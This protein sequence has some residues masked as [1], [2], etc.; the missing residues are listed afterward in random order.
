MGDLLRIQNLEKHYEGFDL[1]GV[2]FSVPA[3]SVVGFIGSN[4]AGKTTTIKAI[5]GLIFPDGGSISL[6]GEEVTSAPE[7]RLAELKQRIGV[8]FDTCSFPEELTVEAVGKLMRHCYKNWNPGKFRTLVQQL[9]LPA[10]KTVK[11]L[12][13]GMGMKLSLA[14]ALA[15]DPDLL[16]LDE[17]TAGL[18]PLARD[19]AL[20]T[21]RLFMNEHRGILMSSH[22]TSDLEKIA[23]Y[24][25]C[26]D[27][28]RIVFAL[29]KDAITDVAGVA[30]CRAA[31]FDAIVDSGI[32]ARGTM[33]F[34]RSVYGTAVLVPDRQAFAARFP[35]VALERA[36]IDSYMSLMLKGEAR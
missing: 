19:E 26:I 21:L 34:E 5:L 15:H 7:K 32:F 2:S 8:V 17:A 30:Q 28:G 25:V 9:G 12:S 33:R 24:I 36:D 29:E 3:G 1:E 20:D 4:G 31:E 27:E 11:D 23:D 18:D 13:R 35:Q 16:V 22:I 14:C 6:F 10:G